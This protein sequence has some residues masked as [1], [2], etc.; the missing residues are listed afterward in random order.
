MVLRYTLILAFL[1]LGAACAPV[2][3]EDTESAQ[4]TSAQTPISDLEPEDVH[5]S[6]Q[7]AD[8]GQS[9]ASEHDEEGEQREHGPHEHGAATL[10][11]AWSGNALQIDLDTPGF[12]LFGFEYEP[13]TEEDIRIV[14]AATADLESGSLLMINDEGNCTLS[15]SDMLTAWDDSDADADNT[16]HADEAHADEEHEE[17][18]ETHS[19]VEVTFSFV[20]ES[21]AELRSLDLGPLFDRFPNFVELDA[22]WISDTNQSA[23]ELTPES[24][25]ITLR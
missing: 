16:E 21:P 14:E 13:T 4:V 3:T 9:A 18:S 12:N 6:E 23:A 1:L 24:P 11:I 2:S 15:G 5:D 17:E 20:C 7:E 8:N 22:Q 25:L 10:S 19:D